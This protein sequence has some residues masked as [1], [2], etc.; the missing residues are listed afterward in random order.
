M[1]FCLKNA[2]AKNARLPP[3]IQPNAGVLS[4]ADVQPGSRFD[5]GKSTVKITSERIHVCLQRYHD[6]RQN[7][8]LVTTRR[9]HRPPQRKIRDSLAVLNHFTSNNSS[10]CNQIMRSGS[11]EYLSQGPLMTS[12][13]ISSATQTQAVVWQEQYALILITR[14]LQIFRHDQDQTSRMESRFL[15]HSQQPLD[16]F[17]G[18][19]INQTD[20]TNTSVDDLFLDDEERALFNRLY[21]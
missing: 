11:P 19:D 18:D 16:K 9:P 1:D 4:N 21:N 20:K 12:G 13:S 17:V 14:Y 6:N 7:L 5:V 8:A 15:Q 2:F 10:V 3:N